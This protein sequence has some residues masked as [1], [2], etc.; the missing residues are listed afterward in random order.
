VLPGFENTGDV[1]LYGIF[2]LLPCLSAALLIALARYSRRN[3]Q[4]RRGPVLVGANV[5]VFVFLLSTVLLAAESYYRFCCDA[6][7][8]Y[9]LTRVSQ[10]WFARHFHNDTSG[11]RDDVPDYALKRTPGRRRIT[12]FGDSF[13]AGHGIANVD[14]RFANRIRKMRPDW[15]I[16]VMAIN[17]SDTG[18]ELDMIG[19]SL[20]QG[21][22]F[23][24]V[25]LVYCLNDI[26][27]LDT[28]WQA[29]MNRFYTTNSLGFFAT[30]S[31]CLNMW[32]YMVKARLQ[33]DI[34][35]Y[36][37][38]LLA[39]Y[40]GPLWEKQKT[41]LRTFRNVVENAGGHPWVV[42]F[43]LFDDLG[44]KYPYTAIHKKLDEFWREIGV[45][46]L[47]LLD[48]YLAHRDRKLTVNSHDPHP[49]EYAHALAA[50][51]ILKFLERSPPQDHPSSAAAKPNAPNQD[52]GLPRNEA[53]SRRPGPDP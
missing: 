53:S 16:Q 44:P 13:T 48:L 7:D 10:R 1:V 6:S 15:E 38:L 50:D 51:A 21:G 26:T 20:S 18:N 8:Q 39:D 19:W 43:P 27:D 33:P 11:L 23:D 42:T 4:R 12:F 22:E 47:D 36:D 45:P 35:H 40:N 5:L 32:Y 37:R 41:R 17:G 2:L 31:F 49:N 29:T 3:P 25:V 28:E 14:D 9:G 24:D 52:S 46:H 34:V 30:H